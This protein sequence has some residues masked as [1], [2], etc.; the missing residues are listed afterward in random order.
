[1][2]VDCRS[3][4]RRTGSRFGRGGAGGRCRECGYLPSS[5]LTF[6]ASADEHLDVPA[7]RRVSVDGLL[8]QVVALAGLL[9]HELARARDLHA[10]A[11][12]LSGS[13]SSAWCRLR[14]VRRSP[15]PVRLSTIWAGGRHMSGSR[16]SER[17]G[18]LRLVRRLRLRCGARSAPACSASRSA[19]RSRPLAR[20]RSALRVR[21][22]LRLLLVRSEHHDHVAAV[23]LR[24]RL[25][26][27]ELLDVAGEPLQQPEPEL[28]SVLLATT[29]HDRDL[30]LVALP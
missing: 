1:M 30:D 28:G 16:F 5:F 24:R 3:P 22:G 21:L 8:L 11:A 26:E 23:L 27:A 6:L 9:A 29:E 12:Y 10:L 7:I 19:A 2:S 13:S 20:S 14:L 18:A 17:R 4:R 25:D 15:G